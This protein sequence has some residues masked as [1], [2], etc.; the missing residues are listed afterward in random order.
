MFSARLSWKLL[1][2]ALK[3]LSW[4]HWSWAGRQVLGHD[5]FQQSFAESQ[6]SWRLSLETPVIMS[7]E[8]RT[9]TVNLTMRKTWWNYS[10]CGNGTV[11]TSKADEP[12][13]TET[14]NLKMKGSSK[15]VCDALHYLLANH[16]SNT[17]YSLLRGSSNIV[18]I[19][20]YQ[21]FFPWKLGSSYITKLPYI[22]I[23]MIY[24]I[25][26]AFSHLGQYFNIRKRFSYKT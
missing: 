14:W 17:P 16:V 1:D 15:P 20:Q 19:P 2:L 3:A 25:T 12:A 11:S 8:C 6:K 4:H 13:N 9:S 5:K 23:Y 10:V 26:I 22:L 24:V 21:F 18:I 7:Y